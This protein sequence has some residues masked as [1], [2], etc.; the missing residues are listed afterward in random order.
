MD[1]E[2]VIESG[3]D[4]TQT[5]VVTQTHRMRRSEKVLALDNLKDSEVEIAIL[6]LSSF[7]L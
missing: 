5:T 3:N 7:A 2:T 4:V 6:G 1:E